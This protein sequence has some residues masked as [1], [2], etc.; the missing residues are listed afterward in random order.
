MGC[1]AS[2]SKVSLSPDL[3]AEIE[4]LF[5]AIHVGPGEETDDAFILRMNLDPK[6]TKECLANLTPERR[7]YVLKN[8]ATKAAET[9]AGVETK[10]KDAGGGQKKATDELVAYI[11]EC[12]KNGEWDKAKAETPKAQDGKAGKDGEAGITRDQACKFFKG[13]FGKLS[14][15][16]MFNE[17][18]V[19][20][21]G[22]ITKVEFVEFWTQVKK[23]GYKEEDIKEE[24][25]EMR[26]G[27]GAWVDWKDDRDVLTKG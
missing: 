3:K 1:G 19:D 20:K 8:F 25:T 26:N 13:K 5:D 23:S 9:E 16:A 7:R 4:A 11:T 22:S 14:A 27:S 24:V 12:G 15:E 17:V 10:D 21:D 6:R 18:D 2:F